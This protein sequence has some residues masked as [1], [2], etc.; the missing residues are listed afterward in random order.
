MMSISNIGPP[1]V[2]ARHLFGLYI[3]VG[4]GEVF[5]AMCIAEQYLVGAAWFNKKVLHS[6]ICSLLR[7]GIT[8][9]LLVRPGSKSGGS[10]STV[11]VFVE[12]IVSCWIYRVC[13][14]ISFV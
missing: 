9:D 3:L 10:S 6:R 2:N 11:L 5:C 4:A 13:Y 8:V 1:S 14:A 12:T 7:P